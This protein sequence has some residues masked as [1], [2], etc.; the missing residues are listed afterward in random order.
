MSQSEQT[1]DP[2]LDLRRLTAIGLW[3]LTGIAAVV[4]GCRAVVGAFDAPISPVLPFLTTSSAMLACTCAWR[5][6][7][8]ATASHTAMQRLSSGL[9]SL[10]PVAVIGFSTSVHAA[11]LALGIT[12]GLL[13]I[14]LV[15][16]VTFEVLRIDV[17]DQMPIGVEE[18]SAV[19]LRPA[20]AEESLD[21]PHLMSEPGTM[22]DASDSGNIVQRI[23]RRRNDDGSELIEAELRATFAVGEKETA[24]HLPIHPVL[25]GTPLVECE[26]LDESDVTVSVPLIQPYGIRIEVKRTERLQERLTVSVGV[27][28]MTGRVIADVA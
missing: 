22:N 10:V 5:M 28:V 1:T 6:H 17:T 23:T 27:A 15:A 9:L 4:F 13:L 20:A 25:T 19:P 2:T 7:A 21:L 11:P 16:V 12:T 24:I 8:L 3:L 26:P 18:H 14:G